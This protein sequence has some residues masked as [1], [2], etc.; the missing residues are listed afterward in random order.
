MLVKAILRILKEDYKIII[1]F[2]V[3]LFVFSYPMPYLISTGGGISNLD[4]RINVEGAT[5][6]E[7]SYNLCYVTQINANLMSYLLSYVIPTW[8]LEELNLYKIVETDTN[9]EV[10]LRGKI[11]LNTS[12]E[13]ATFVAY[14]EANKEVNIKS[15]NYYITAIQNPNINK[16][17]VGDILVSIDG[18]SS[19]EFDKLEDIIDSKDELI[20]KVNREGKE[21]T[22]NVKVIE[23][24]GERRIG[25]Y[26]YVSYDFDVNPSI[27]FTF[28]KDESGGSAGLMTSLSIYDA[29]VEEDLTHGLKIA[30]TGTINLNGKVGSIGGVNYK[31]MGA[32]KKGADIFFV[33]SGKNYEDAL[34]TKKENKYDIK[35]IP[36]TYF[37]DA[38][39]YLEKIK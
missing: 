35:I 21:I 39:D 30:G 9:K 17:Q 33:P 5:K 4:E 36:I 18:Y 28:N 11:S 26:F 34:K 15:I 7:G 16:I 22:E 3:F 12:N 2:L 29:L 1:F 37:Q 32:Y 14:K 20:I 25:L 8:E 13:I 23:I 27:S 6:Q 38:I 10:D 19:D 24:D 31:L